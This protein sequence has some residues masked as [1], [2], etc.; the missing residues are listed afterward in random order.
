MSRVWPAVVLAVTAAPAAAQVIDDDPEIREFVLEN[1]AGTRLRFIN[2]GAI[3]TSIEVPS[4][5]SV[6][7]SS[8]ISAIS[9]WRRCP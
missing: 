7:T 8:A 4:R 6:L 3:I 9:R 5:S 2:Y 1:S